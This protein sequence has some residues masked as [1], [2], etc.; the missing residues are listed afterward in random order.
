MYM[1]VIFQGHV[2]VLALQKAPNAH[3]VLHHFVMK[4]TPVS[5]LIYMGDAHNDQ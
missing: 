1:N 5:K 3:T 4:P 2:N